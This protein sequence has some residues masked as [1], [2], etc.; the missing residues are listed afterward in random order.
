MYFA[1]FIAW[2]IYACFCSIIKPTLL[3]N[4]PIDKNADLETF[5]QLVVDICTIIEK[6]I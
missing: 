2:S 3:Q 4:E 5:K 6:F 1:L